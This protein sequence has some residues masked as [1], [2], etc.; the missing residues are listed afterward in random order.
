LRVFRV[1]FCVN[2]F[3]AGVQAAFVATRDAMK[4]GSVPP[5]PFRLRAF[6]ECLTRSSLAFESHIAACRP[7]VDRLVDSMAS[8][9]LD[10]QDVYKIFPIRYSIH[11]F[12]TAAFNVVGAL[13]GVRAA[14]A[15]AAA[16]A[17]SHA[18]A[19]CGRSCARI[20]HTRVYSC[21]AAAAVHARPTRDTITM[22]RVLGPEILRARAPHR[23]WRTRR[24]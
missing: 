11:K 2:V 14:A 19:R 10:D 18:R 12:E 17:G 1:Q 8:A 3:R 16:A 9:D 13:K 15:A 22:T 20:R 23:C 7:V 5:L 24:T 4:V 6:E 21:A